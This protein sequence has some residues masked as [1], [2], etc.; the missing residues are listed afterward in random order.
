MPFSVNPLKDYITYEFPLNE[1]IRLFMR[2]EQLF[3][4]IHHFA[5]V[6]RSGTVAP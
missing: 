4:Q 1:R 3:Q 5:G 2:V 6:T